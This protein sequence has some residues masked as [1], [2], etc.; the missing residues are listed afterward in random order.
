MKSL[1]SELRQRLIELKNRYLPEGFVILGVFGSVARGD[2]R[3]ESDIDLLYQVEP[4]FLER[5]G[6]FAGLTR[7]DEIKQELMKA[8]GRHVDLAPKNT[9]NRVLHDEIARDVVYV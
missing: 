1:Q 9:A 2:D 4:S 3:P 5:Y 7:F 6:G 8:L